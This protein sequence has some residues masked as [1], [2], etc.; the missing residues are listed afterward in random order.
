[1]DP[2]VEL[3]PI[4]KQRRR[5]L[6]REV[7]YLADRRREREPDMAKRHS[8][9]RFSLLGYGVCGSSQWDN[10]VCGPDT[11][12]TCLLERGQRQTICFGRC[13][14]DR[15]DGH[16]EWRGYHLHRQ[17]GN[18]RVDVHERHRSVG[19]TEDHRRERCQQDNRIRGRNLSERSDRQPHGQSWRD[20]LGRDGI[21][22]LGSSVG[23]GDSDADEVLCRAFFADVVA[24][25]YGSRTPGPRPTE[26]RPGSTW[27]LALRGAGLGFLLATA[28]GRLPRILR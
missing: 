13:I 12:A 11:R 20:P 6:H 10:T 7:A 26:W 17:F 28:A 24:R 1:M 15:N 19:W 14:P 3:C 27:R 23:A 8:G 16:A 18:K 5:P 2:A 21:I 9:F 22:L 4:D 25:G